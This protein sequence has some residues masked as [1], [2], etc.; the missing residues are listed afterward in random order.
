MN[1]E[2]NELEKCLNGE[3]YDCHDKVFLNLKARARKL[4]K[5][6]HALAYE[7]K[8]EKTRILKQLFAQIG[9]NV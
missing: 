8:E 3:Y 2:G 5:E 4:L 1:Y 7:Q 6:Y 9:S